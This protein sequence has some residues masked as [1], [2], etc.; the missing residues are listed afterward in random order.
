MQFTDERL[1]E[2][3]RLYKQAYGEEISVDDARHLA[4]RL[5]MLYRTF[6]AIE[7]RERKKQTP[8]QSAD[9]AA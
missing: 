5:V 8:E 3:R 1:E 2:F 9:K 6:H 7:L 4:H